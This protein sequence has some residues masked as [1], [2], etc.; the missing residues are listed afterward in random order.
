M[1]RTAFFISDG[2]GITAET[3]GRSLLAQFENTDIRMVTKPYIDSAEKATAL[4]KAIESAH[5]NDGERPIIIDTIVDQNI[6]DIISESSGF[7]VDIFSTFLKPLEEELDTHSSYSVGK[8]HS[9]GQ[10]D[11]YMNRIDSVHF[12]LDNDDGAR[13]HQ[14][15]KA[16]VI[17]IGVSRCGKTPTSLYLA[18]QFGIR[19]ANYPLTEDDLDES[20]TLK[21][22]A[23]LAQ[24]RHKLFGLTIDPRRLAA[25]RTERRPNSRY[26]SIDQCLQEVEQTEALFRRSK[27]PYIDTTRFSIEEIST[28]MI[29]ETGLAR[30][31]SP[32]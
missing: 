15:D 5:A 14:Y 10:D 4:V 32:R 21:M 31:F 24:Y 2:T 27:V 18:L 1:T 20:G 13:T 28:R 6:R 22:P 30:R 8:T 23:S 19:A 9:I 11:V 17:L 12:A 7:K 3:L 26:C 29:A 16:D 25:I